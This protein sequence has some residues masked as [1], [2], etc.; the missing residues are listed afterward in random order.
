MLM[1]EGITMMDKL[2]LKRHSTQKTTAKTAMATKFSDNMIK[3]LALSVQIPPNFMWEDIDRE[4]FLHFIDC[5]DREDAHW[6]RNLCAVV[7][8]TESCIGLPTNNPHW[9]KVGLSKCWIGKGLILVLF[10]DLSYIY[11]YIRIVDI[12][13]YL[14]TTEMGKMPTWWADDGYTK[15]FLAT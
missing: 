9:I 15:L 2:A 1:A 13:F 14:F 3:Y 12:S 8:C 5:C 11:M 4:I 10:L 7:L 6:R